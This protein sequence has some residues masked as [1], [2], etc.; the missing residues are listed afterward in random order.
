MSEVK[1]LDRFFYQIDFLPSQGIEEL[2]AL[3]QSLEYVKYAEHTDALR[4]ILLIQT[5]SDLLHEEVEENLLTFFTNNKITGKFIDDP[6]I[7]TSVNL[8]VDGMTCAA[9]VTAIERRLHKID[10]ISEANVNLTTQQANISY[11]SQEVKLASIVEAIEQIGYG[12]Q[13]SEAGIQIERLK[14]SEEIKKWKTY[15]I[16]SLVFSLPIVFLS[17]GADGHLSFLTPISNLFGFVYDPLLSTKIFNVSLLYFLLLFLS[18]FPQV[19]V[20]Y[21]FYRPSYNALRHR[22]F[23]MDSLVSL[24]TLAAYLYSVFEIFL[25]LFTADHNPVVFFET[26]IV[27]FAFISFGKFL[28]ALAKS[29]SSNAIRSLMEKQPKTALRVYPDG[30]EEEIQSSYIEIGDVLQVNPYQLVPTDGVVEK[31]QS[32]VDESLI[33]GESVPVEK[34]SGDKIT[35]GTLNQQHPL[36]IRATRIGSDTYLSQIG[37][38]IQNAQSSKLP[39]QSVADKVAF[40][41]VPIVLVLGFLTFTIWF[42][43]LESGIIQ[44]SNLDLLFSHSGLTSGD[45]TF[46]NFRFSLLSTIS[47]LVISCACAFG[48]A[49]PIAVLVGTSLGAENGILIKGGDPLESAGNIDAMIFD[50]TGTLTQGN[51]TVTDFHRLNQESS[52]LSDSDLLFLAG[53][54]ESRSE[55]PLA[56]ALLSYTT[57]Q[58]NKDVKFPSEF[59]ILRGLGVKARV[60]NYEIAVGNRKLLEEEVGVGLS[61][62]A[63]RLMIELERSG[64]TAIIIVVNGIIEGLMGIADEVREES[65]AVVSYLKKQGIQVSMLTGD[66]ERTAQSISKALNIDSFTAEVLPGDK[67]GHVASLQEQGY[68]VGMVGDGVNDAPALAQADVGFALSSGTSIALESSDVT[69][70]RNNLWDVPAAIN[71]SQATLR[72]IKMNMVFA[73]GYNF[74]GIPLAAGVGLFLILFGLRGI[75]LPPVFAGLAMALSSVSVVVSSLLL[76]LHKV[77]VKK[78]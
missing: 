1:V 2:V 3:L 43:L 22:S 19:Y 66:N 73:F 53:S 65:A 31:G 75:N 14:R 61:E 59:E 60:D 74:L 7:I 77:D 17:I 35:G 76:R 49:A 11:A 46:D 78:Q 9:C 34:E 40:Y 37:T 45:T 47:V 64:K 72:R 69:L 12:A 48:L 63:D 42:T 23:N 10:G 28:G 25:A 29:R 38:L 27:L 36:Q 71:L 70:A 15:F 32:Y 8:N 44:L 20:G 26:A 41:L 18:T 58:G 21:G 56:K 13:P 6:D 52:K 54:A 33:T 24:G 57:V 39:I 16:V 51:L 5:S 50:K 4:R 67:A 62:E 68:V 55:H 30:T